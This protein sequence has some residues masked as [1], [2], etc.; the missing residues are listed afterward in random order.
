VVQRAESPRDATPF[1]LTP[2]LLTSLIAAILCTIGL[3]VLWYVDANSVAGPP[4]TPGTRPPPPPSPYIHATLV[5]A[6]GTFVITWIAVM[7]TA[8]RDQ[9]VRRIDHIADRVATAATE[10]AEQR[11][12]EGVFHG[13]KIAATN[14]PPDPDPGSAA[15]VV[16]F[17]R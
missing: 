16:P 5:V 14:H 17:P 8:I 12:E 6:S 9:V 3:A 15:Q 2:L 7:A 13:I 10:F 1:Q 4:P 11:E